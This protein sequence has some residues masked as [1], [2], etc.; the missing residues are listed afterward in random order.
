LKTPSGLAS[1]HLLQAVPEHRLA[2]TTKVEPSM[3]DAFSGQVRADLPQSSHSQAPV[4]LTLGSIILKNSPTSQMS[5][6]LAFSMAGR[7]RAGE[8]VIASSQPPSIAQ[9]HKLGFKDVAH[10]QQVGFKLGQ[11]VDVVNLQLLL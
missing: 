3:L 8:D 4:S 10:L 1:W 5:L 7:G 2:S 9:H 11:W 6:G